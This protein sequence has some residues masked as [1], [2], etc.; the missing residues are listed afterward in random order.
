[1]IDDDNHVTYW[2]ISDKIEKAGNLKHFQFKILLF[3]KK[4]K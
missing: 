4:D 2:L 3:V 1:M